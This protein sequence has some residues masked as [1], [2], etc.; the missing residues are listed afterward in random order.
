M[1]APRPVEE[2]QIFFRVKTLAEKAKEDEEEA[3]DTGFPPSNPPSDN[4]CDGEEGDKE[5]ENPDEEQK[6]APG[7]GDGGEETKKAEGA[8][9]EEKVFDKVI[10]VM[11]KIKLKG[12]RK[13]ILEE[14][15]VQDIC[16]ARL[17]MMPDK[18]GEND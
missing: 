6:E 16:T 18:S 13:A 17:Y 1:G 15:G 8:G 10:K 2:V 5:E 11:P 3:I 7:G 9:Q 12:I 4:E 14:L